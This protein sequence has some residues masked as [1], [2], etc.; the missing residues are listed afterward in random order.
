MSYDGRVLL[1]KFVNVMVTDLYLQMCNNQN[2]NYLYAIFWHFVEK[3][4]KFM[5]NTHYKEI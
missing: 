5:I 3:V 4:I 2:N 1:L